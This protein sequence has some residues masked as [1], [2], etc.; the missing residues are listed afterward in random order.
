MSRRNE[1]ITPDDL[2]EL[3]DLI[4]QNNFLKESELSSEDIT[5]I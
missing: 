5:H 2:L 3:T 4:E 1:L